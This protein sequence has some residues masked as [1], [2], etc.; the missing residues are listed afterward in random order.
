MPLE[1]VWNAPSASN[2]SKSACQNGEWI[3]KIYKKL[4][5]FD[6]IIF[7]ACLL[8]HSF[9][10]YLDQES[11]SKGAHLDVLESFSQHNDQ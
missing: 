2:F 4:L 6:N 3:S 8:R 7:A 10:L 1:G 11:K 5:I 9:K